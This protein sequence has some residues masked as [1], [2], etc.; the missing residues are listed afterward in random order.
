VVTIAD[1]SSLRVEADVSE[2]NLEKV[3][4]GQPCEILL[5]ALPGSR[6]RGVVH[7]IVPTA[8]R[9]KATVLVKVS[10]VDRDP[11]ILPE[12]SAKVAFLERQVNAGEQTAKTV[13][14]PAAI[15]TRSGASHVYLLKG[16]R[17]EETRVSLGGKV[18][19]MQE[20]TAG[21]KAGDRIAVKPLEKL[22]HG[23]RIKSEVK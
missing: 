19:D 13:V 9:S 7:T 21:V 20:V 1:L 23:S 22:K 17:V 3:K 12:M 5:D 14:P 10:F 8:D 15:V 18:G 4:V 6:F 11:R 2:S 16:E